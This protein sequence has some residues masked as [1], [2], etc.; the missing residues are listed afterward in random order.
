MS[1]I[2]DIIAWVE[3]DGFRFEENN[4]HFAEYDLE[5]T[6]MFCHAKWTGDK[7]PDYYMCGASI[8]Y[9]DIESWIG[10]FEE[11]IKGFHAFGA[12]AL[13]SHGDG[14]EVFILGYDLADTYK[15]HRTNI[16]D[17]NTYNKGVEYTVPLLYQIIHSLYQKVIQ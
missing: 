4:K 16:A 14:D 9:C 5:F 11:F 1:R 13:I 12:T 15:K 8:N 17:V 7:N 2:T 6:K 3:A 10:T